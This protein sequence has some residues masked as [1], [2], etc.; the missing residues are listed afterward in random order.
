MFGCFSADERR[1]GHSGALQRIRGDLVYECLPAGGLVFWSFPEDQKRTGDLVLSRGP[2]EDWWS[3]VSRGPGEDW[4]SGAVQR[5][6][7]GL[8][9]WCSPDDQRRTGSL[10][11]SRGPEEDW[12][13][14]APQRTRGGL[15]A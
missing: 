10:V 5:T 11:L 6:R 13:S 2:G 8:G 3:G 7:R 1:T 4:E 9:V 12:E 15:G 14:G